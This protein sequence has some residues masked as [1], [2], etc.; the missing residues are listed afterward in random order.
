MSDL[1]L[2]SDGTDFVVAATAQR[3]REIS[4]EQGWGDAEDPEFRPFELVPPET[5][6]TVW[7]RDE[8]GQPS[9]VKPAAEWVA[10]SE[11]GLLCSTEY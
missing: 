5:S 8:E 11:E 9:Y 3:A 4:V 10:E 7:D 1:H 6:I 2:W